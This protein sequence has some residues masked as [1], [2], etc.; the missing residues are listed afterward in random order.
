MKR[1][2]LM[3]LTLTLILGIFSSCG[4]RYLTVDD[5]SSS[6][7]S[8]DTTKETND[9][10]AVTTTAITQD[11]LDITSEAKESLYPTEYSYTVKKDVAAS[12]SQ[13]QEPCGYIPNVGYH[14]AL[15]ET[16]TLSLHTSM[17][18]Q[19]ASCL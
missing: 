1:L 15:D 18:R 10:G 6:S 9:T 12:S 8:E 19:Y 11:T 7:P 4:K 5:E 13:R 3:L 14:S 16:A 17:Q 2:L